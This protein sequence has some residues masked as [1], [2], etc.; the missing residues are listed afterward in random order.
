MIRNKLIPI[1]LIF[2]FIQSCNYKTD[3]QDENNELKDSIAFLNQELKKY[4]RL[5]QFESIRPMLIPKDTLL[6]TGEESTFHLVLQGLNFKRNHKL[7]D[8]SYQVK[9]DLQSKLNWSI[10]DK[11][12]LLTYQPLDIGHDTIV[13][14]FYYQDPDSVQSW[15]YSTE[16]PVEIRK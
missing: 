2:V 13:A 4:D 5:F 11:E 10:K 9:T 3:L 1:F 7:Y 12:H 14:N 16:F 15:E 6:R 8:L